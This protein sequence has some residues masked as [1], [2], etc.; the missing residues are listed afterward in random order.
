MAD[1]PRP[2]LKW[3]GGKRQLLGVIDSQLPPEVKNGKI[4]TYVE[5]MVG[6]AAVFFHMR[7]KYGNTLSKYYISD[8]NWDLY[9]LYRTI[10]SR[11]RD[12]I[13]E[14]QT[15]ADEYLPLPPTQKGDKEGERIS[16]YKR[17]RE[18]YNEDE[19]D[20]QRYLNDGITFRRRPTDR[21]VRRAAMTIFLNRTCF[22]GL[23]RVNSSGK[24]NVP[25]GRYDNPDIVDEEN[26]Q[27]VSKALKDV[28]ISVGSYEENL[29]MVDDKTF[30][31][32]DPP[33]RPLPNTPSFTDY[34]K[35][36]FGDSEQAELAQMYTQLH[37][38]GAKLMLSNSDPKNTDEE[39][40]F[41]DM[42]YEEFN[43]IRVSA[44]RAISSDGAGRGAISEI[45][46]VNYSEADYGIKGNPT[47]G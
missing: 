18:E 2:V 17:I 7:E 21:W 20:N 22:N 37:A 12:L 1:T 5:P 40:E 16:M 44:I 23:Y 46:V 10:Q 25:H 11:V 3:A 13:E 26:L 8:Y 38:R 41:F 31:Y 39:D 19:W 32:F 33:Y 27:A 6:G 24:F 35:A 43:I 28:E 29:D 42:L 34:H 36:A 45:L 14:L 47:A 30:V 4:T 9:V 15:L